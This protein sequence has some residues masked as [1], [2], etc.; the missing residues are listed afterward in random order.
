[1]AAKLRYIKYALLGAILVVS[2]AGSIG[3]FFGV[4]I[5]DPGDLIAA[6]TGGGVGALLAKAYALT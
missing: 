1:M 3:S 4:E 6:A 5:G 2:A